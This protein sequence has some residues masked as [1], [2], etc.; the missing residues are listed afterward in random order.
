[1]AVDEIDAIERLAGA[2]HRVDQAD[3]DEAEVRPGDRVRLRGNGRGQIDRGGVSV[4]CGGDRER[5]VGPHPQPQ[6]KTV[7][8]EPLHLDVELQQ[9]PDVEPDPASRRGKNGP[10]GLVV[11]RD[12]AESQGEAALGARQRSRANRHHVARA[13]SLLQ[14]LG[15]TRIEADEIDR[16]GEEEIADRPKRDADREHDEHGAADKDPASSRS[17]ALPTRASRSLAPAAVQQLL[18]RGPR[19]GP[20]H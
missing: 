9:R 3:G 10:A 11:D 8:I 6:I 20:R 19:P 17:E 16:P 7:K 14:A 1:M 15:D 13:E 5:A 4:G 2:G 18:D 12:A